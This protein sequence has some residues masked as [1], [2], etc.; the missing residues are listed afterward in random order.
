MD[1]NE[2]Y[3]LFVRALLEEDADAARE[4][5]SNL[6]AWMERGGFEPD[7]FSNPLARKQFFM[8]SRRTGRLS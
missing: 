8:F 1:P 6:R 4:A 2:T 5:Y 3:R 7:A